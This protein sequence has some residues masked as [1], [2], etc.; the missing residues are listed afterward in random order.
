MDGPE[1]E[2]ESKASAGVMLRGNK[3]DCGRLSGHRR[4]MNKADYIHVFQEDRAPQSGILS[5]F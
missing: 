4:R 1:E 5:F 3:K 2:E